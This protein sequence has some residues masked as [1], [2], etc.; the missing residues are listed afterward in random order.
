MDMSLLIWI[1]VVSSFVLWTSAACL[2]RL[3]IHSAPCPVLPPANRLTW[4]QG[5]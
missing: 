2:G 5:D 1:L 3:I 4:P